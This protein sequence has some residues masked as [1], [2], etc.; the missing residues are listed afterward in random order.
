MNTTV[1]PECKCTACGASMDRATHVGTVTP[2]PGDVAICFDCGHVMIFAD[3]LTVRDPTDA[4]IHKIAGDREVV[5]AQKF[6]QESA[7]PHRLRHR[8]RD[9]R[10]YVIP[11]AQFIK[12][13]GT[14]DFATMDHD[15]TAKCLRFRVCGICGEQLGRHIYFVGGPLCVVNR[16]FYDPAMHREC[17]VYALE[18][19]PHIT[20]A[21]GRYRPLHT[22]K[23]EEGVKRIVG[24]VVTEVKAEYFA[25]MHTTA[26]EW[27]QA[28]DGMLMG[29]AAPWLD[30]EYWQHGK[31]VGPVP[32]VRDESDAR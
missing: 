11:F 14:P 28:P 22:F 27:G 12:A 16:L 20:T 7:I 23:D 18:T 17:A 4:E 1:M 21:K 29:K 25:L 15:K 5:A 8:P 9:H 26:Y 13:D 2:A 24:K 10:G 30:V 6:R 3:D 32:P 19:C 31:A